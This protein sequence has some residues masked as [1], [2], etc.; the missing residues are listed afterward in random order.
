MSYSRFLKFFALL[1]LVVGFSASQAWAQ[2]V[3]SG[4]IDGTVTDPAGAVVPNATVSLGSSETG[5]NESTTTG[6]N[7]TFRFALVK[8]GSYTL[9]VSVGGFRTAKNHC[10]CFSRSGYQRTGQA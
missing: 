5:T 3:V 1:L 4:E 2:S 10:G 7:G 9:T 8:P 6:S